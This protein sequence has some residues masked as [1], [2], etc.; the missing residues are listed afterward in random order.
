MAQVLDG[1]ASENNAD[2]DDALPDLS[3][4]TLNDL[5]GPSL[6]NNFS[7]DPSGE[8]GENGDEGD[9]TL[10]VLYL[11]K[12]VQ[13]NNGEDDIADEWQTL[14]TEQCTTAVTEM[15]EEE[16]RSKRTPQT[17]SNKS[18][19]LP[20]ERATVENEMKQGTLESVPGTYYWTRMPL[21]L[22]PWN[23]SDTIAGTGSGTAAQSGISDANESP[24]ATSHYSPSDQTH[25]PGAGS[26]TA[27]L[28]Q[29]SES[30]TSQRATSHSFPTDPT[31]HF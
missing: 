31:H 26:G 9:E 29:I 2:A 17:E 4:L 1:D 19:T 10:P 25:T 6:L 24:G 13:N 14:T 11:A 22:P 12:E 30:N 7:I 15:E 3:H 20:E 21:V 28:S 8:D 27:T 23:E 5:C 16:T 18:G